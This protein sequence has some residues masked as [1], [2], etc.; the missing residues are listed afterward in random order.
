M[1]NKI[2]SIMENKL[3]VI[4]AVLFCIIT[5]GSCQSTTKKMDK[6]EMKE[7]LVK[8]L[9]EYSEKRIYYVQVNKG[10]CRV[11]LDVNDLLLHNDFTEWGSTGSIP[12][13]LSILKS[14]KQSLLVK[15]YPTLQ[16]KTLTDITR[17]QITVTYGKTPNSSIEEQ[18]TVLDWNLPKE[19]IDQKLPYYET[20]LDF[21]AAV[22]YDYTYRLDGAVDLRKIPNIEQ[23]A[24]EK[25]KE[26]RQLYEAGDVE[27]YWNM[28]FD[29]YSQYAN[30][31]YQTSEEI[32]EDIEEDIND[33]NTQK[34]N[35][36]ILPIDNY[37]IFFYAEGKIIILLERE[38]R[39]TLIK[40]SYIDN[41]GYKSKIGLPTELY[42]PKGSNELMIF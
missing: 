38:T 37:E 20:T 36:E 23:L 18:V 35:R 10:G 5:T 14:G 19:I 30:S 21:D 7:K 26:I 16:Q 28:V 4:V 25:M 42:M 11:E 17:L 6:K 41:Q 33:F 8:S 12:M 2:L 22:P 31:L 1:Y 40:C 34:K 39:G 3:L 15:I 27:T 24:L 13:N 9:K 32:S 29:K